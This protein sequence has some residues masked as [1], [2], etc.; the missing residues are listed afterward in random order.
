MG[1]EASFEDWWADVN[2]FAEQNRL[3]THYVEEEFIIDGEFLPVHLKFE[4]DYSEE[5]IEK[6]WSELQ[7]EQELISD[8]EM[9]EMK[10]EAAAYAQELKSV[11]DVV[12][13]SIMDEMAME[14]LYDQIRD[15]QDDKEWDDPLM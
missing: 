13:D 11:E 12:L 2:A 1:F 15:A 7:A 3:P 4:Q 6:M 10:N 14:D 5:E 8:E 9:A